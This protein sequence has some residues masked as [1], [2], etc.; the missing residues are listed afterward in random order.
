MAFERADRCFRLRPGDG[1]VVG[2]GVFGIEPDARITV[3]NPVAPA[4]R[5]SELRFECPAVDAPIDQF[6]WVIL[7]R[8][9]D[10]LQAYAEQCLLLP[11]CV[12]PGFQCRTTL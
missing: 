11:F 4:L 8:R 9:G 1:E 3:E 5:I 2:R 10:H 6:C 12:L 7:T